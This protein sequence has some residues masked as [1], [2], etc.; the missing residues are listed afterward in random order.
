MFVH[1][2]EDDR[3]QPFE[4][5]VTLGKAGGSAMADAE[6]MGRMISLAL[7]SGIPLMEVHRQLR[8]IS[9]D[10][11]V[12]L[13]PNKVLSVPDAIG[14]A[15]EEWW[16][17]RTLGVQQDLLTVTG[18]QPVVSG[19]PEPVV[20]RPVSSAASA[21][22]AQAQLSFDAYNGGETFMGTCPDCGSQLEYAEGCVK[23]HVCGFSECG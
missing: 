21:A 5:F 17:D 22:E 19:S 7:R 4:V 2:T 12:G 16:R 13:G 3:G 18:E 6:A 11:A 14:L 1:I 20:V 8:G 15:L 9:S 23:C 10:R